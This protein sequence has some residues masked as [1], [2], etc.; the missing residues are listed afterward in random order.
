MKCPF[1][2]LPGGKRKHTSL[3]SGGNVRCDDFPC[4]QYKRFTAVFERQL[5]AISR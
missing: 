2:A 3:T 1:F 5:S 4:L